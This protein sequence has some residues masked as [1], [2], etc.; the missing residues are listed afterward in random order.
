[1]GD[2][3]ILSDFGYLIAAIIGLAIGIWIEHRN[4]ANGTN[5][6]GNGNHADG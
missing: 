3:G 4:K 1:M 2:P 6:Q 5:L